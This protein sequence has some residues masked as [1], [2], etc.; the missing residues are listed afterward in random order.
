MTRETLAFAMGAAGIVG[1]LVGFGLIW[2]ALLTLGARR[3][4]GYLFLAG[5]VCAAGGILLFSLHYPVGP[6]TLGGMR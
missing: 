3:L 6:A 5:L 2:L 4:P 1:M